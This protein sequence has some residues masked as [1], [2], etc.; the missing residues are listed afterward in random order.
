SCKHSHHHIGQSGRLTDR[1]LPQLACGRL[2]S[3]GGRIS[4]PFCIKHPATAMSVDRFAKYQR[5][6]IF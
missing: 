6:T 4:A 1:L 3:K 5:I 2:F